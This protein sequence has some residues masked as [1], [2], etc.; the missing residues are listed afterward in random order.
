MKIEVGK[1]YRNRNRELV[2]IVDMDDRDGENY[3]FM[4][5]MGHYYTATGL[6][7]WNDKTDLDLIECVEREKDMEYEGVDGTRG[8]TFREL[9][10]ANAARQLEY[11]T[12]TPF[13]TSYWLIAITGELGELCNFIK[14]Q[15]RDGKDYS[16]EIAKEIADIQIYLDLL[17]NHIGLDMEQAIKQKFNE[18]SDRIGSKVKL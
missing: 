7:S 5:E 10:E 16:I 14:K 17:A 18:V 8:L 11:P 12:K 6:W 4:S 13:T 1:T 2:K 3:P 15:D 9:R